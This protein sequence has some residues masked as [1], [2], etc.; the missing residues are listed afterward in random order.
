MRLVQSGTDV[1]LQ[2][3]SNGLSS[4]ENYQNAIV[5]QNT[6]AGAFKPA[7]FF[8]GFNP[9]GSG[10]FGE[11][12]SGTGAGETLNGT[13]GDDTLSGL[14]G[15]DILN[16]GNGNDVLNGGDGDDLLSGGP[17]R[18]SLTGGLGLDT[19]D[20]NAHASQDT[21]TDFNVAQGDRLDIK[22]MLVGYNGT[23]PLANY[24][25]LAVSG[26]DTVV[27]VDAD[28]TGTAYGTMPLVTL[29]GVTGLLLP[30]LHLVVS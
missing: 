30:D 17:G 1:V 28:G 14:A 11:V 9:D 8:P 25:Q 15:N 13:I 10:I 12:I 20:F 22:D 26:G 19:F 4:G 5:F 2:I 3:D 6:T 7:N 24:V 16:G 27:S 21:I 18:D 23:Q 29:S